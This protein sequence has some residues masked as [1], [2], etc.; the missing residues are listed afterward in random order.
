MCIEN[1]EFCIK[2]DEFCSYFDANPFR[3]MWFSMVE[4]W[5]IIVRNSNPSDVHPMVDRAIFR[6]E[7]KTTAQHVQAL[8]HSV[9]RAAFVFLNPFTRTQTVYMQRSMRLLPSE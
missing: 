2:N 7:R 4:R 8:N 3:R 5:N 6:D 1:K 9:F